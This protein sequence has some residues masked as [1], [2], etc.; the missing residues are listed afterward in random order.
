MGGLVI[1]NK[2]LNKYFAFLKNL[3]NRTKKNL[4]SK[5]S[6][7]MERKSEH[8]SDL[9]SM[10]GAWEDDRSS[11]EIIFEIKNSRVNKTDIESFG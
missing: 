4:I 6:Q 3:D 5:L 8:E 1:S 9:E 11:D 2:T 10:F 7:S